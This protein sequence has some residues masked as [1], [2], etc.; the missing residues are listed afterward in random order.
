MKELGYGKNY[1]YDHATAEGFSGQNYF[2]DNLQ[3]PLFY[4][5]VDRGFEREM[6]KRLAYFF[7][8]R[9]CKTP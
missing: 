5:P 4:E 3:R 7:K 8:L 9:N 2:P 6:Q 1:T